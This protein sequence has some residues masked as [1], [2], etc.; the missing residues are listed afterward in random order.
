[1]SIK[2]K[3]EENRRIVILGVVFFVILI[4]LYALFGA[5][6]LEKWPSEGKIQDSIDLLKKKQKEFQL[7][8][9][10]DNWRVK[11]RESF[12]INSKN[13]WIPARDGNPEA[14]AQK[15]I[16][17][18]AE[19]AGLQIQTLGKVNTTIIA[20][21]ISQMDISVQAKAPIGPITAFIEQIYKRS[22]RFYWAVISLGPDNLRDPKEV[23]INGTI[24]FV[25]ITDA[26]IGEKLLNDKMPGNKDVETPQKLPSDKIPGD[27]NVEPP[28]KL[29]SE[30]IPG[31]KNVETPNKLPNDKIPG[32]KHGTKKK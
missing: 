17:E 20:E 32:D 6:I 18:A 11:N 27:K 23:T 19:N 31:N 7:E 29:P 12:I 16:E 1:M 24:R 9:N 21:G 26:E 25:S 13:F 14:T 30:K 28:K 5:A 15:R 10:K 8:L 2:Q 4:F 22:P 3:F